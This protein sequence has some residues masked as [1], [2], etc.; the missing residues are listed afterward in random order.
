MASVGHSRGLFAQSTALLGAILAVCVCV[1]GAGSAVGQV[2]GVPPSVTS[3]QYHVPPFLPNIRPSVTSLGPHPAYNLSPYPQPYGVQRNVCTWGCRHTGALGYNRGY[4][5]G[6][7]PIYAVP[8][9]DVGDAGPYVYSG[10]PAEQTLHV[11]VDLPPGTRLATEDR[12][13]PVTAVVATPQ[14]ANDETP[15]DATVLVFRDGHR[16]E[17]SS[18]AIMGETLYVLDARK[19]KIGLSDLDLPSTIEVN[20]ERGVDFQLPKPSHS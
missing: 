18:Y 17:I 7:A 3:I 11:V 12:E 6:Y 1:I 16:Q 15:I 10:P 5:A 4:A 2:H 9:Y 19:Q 14:S 13:I 8:V 20:D